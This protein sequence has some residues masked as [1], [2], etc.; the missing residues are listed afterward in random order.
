MP[1][2]KNLFFVG[3]ENTFEL[4]K[5]LKNW[6][7]AAIKKY[8]E[9]AVSR[10]D[11]LESDPQNLIAELKTPPFFGAEKRIFFLENFPP[12]PPSRPFSKE[13]KAAIEKVATIL[14]NLSDENVVVCAV[15]KPDRRTAA[16]KKLDKIFGEKKIF[17]AFEKTNSGIL[18]AAGRRAATDFARKNVAEKGGKILP[19]AAA[20]LVDFCGGDPWK[21][22]RE[23]SKLVAFSAA[24]QKPISEAD[25][26]K[27]ATPSDE[28]ANF[29]FSN[30]IQSGDLFEILAVIEKL[31]TAG[32]APAA[33]LARDASPTI[34]QLLAV[35]SA[36][37]AAESGV[38]PF[39]FSKMKRAADR[40]SAKKLRAAHEKL[41]KID[42]ESKI[43]L[44]PISPQKTRLF[45]LFLE[46]IFLE[47]FAP[48]K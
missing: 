35:K 47:L 27:M 25:I 8:G 22:D 6:E 37:T 7:M 30:A 39:V 31:L 44:L 13:K 12:P 5:F 11:F 24:Q 36:K 2:K 42:F 38:H 41:L 14:E 29:A 34:R 9:F 1:K 26:K 32:D 28:M 23:I 3:G 10:V 45:Q 46:R 43:G 20:F 33:I 18:S 48:E 21:L 16:F 17:P 40:F 15:A 4:A 19:A